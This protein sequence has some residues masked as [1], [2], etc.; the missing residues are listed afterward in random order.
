MLILSGAQKILIYKINRFHDVQIKNPSRT[1][2]GEI[3]CSILQKKKLKGGKP[4]YMYYNVVN[5]HGHDEFEWILYGKKT[6]IKKG[7]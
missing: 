4:R 2:K 5:T 1:T 3:Y 6:N 7:T